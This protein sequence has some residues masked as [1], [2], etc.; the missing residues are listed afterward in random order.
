MVDS[1]EVP[2]ALT[3]PFHIISVHIVFDQSQNEQYVSNLGIPK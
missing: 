1:D 3:V 2:S